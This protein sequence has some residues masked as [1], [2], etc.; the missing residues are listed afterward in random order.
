MTH[1]FWKLT[2]E[3]TPFFWAHTEWPLFSMKILHRIPLLLFSSKYMYIIFIFECLPDGRGRANAVHSDGVDPPHPTSSPHQKKKSSTLE[4]SN[5]RISL[6]FLVF[7][8]KFLTPYLETFWIDQSMATQR[9]CYAGSIYGILNLKIA[10]IIT[11]ADAKLVISGP[12]LAI[13]NAHYV[14]NLQ[15]RCKLMMSHWLINC[16]LWTGNCTKK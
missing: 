11:S 14:C 13:S 15:D 10:F 1:I 5:P 12:I 16:F 2:P 3:K 6:F 8:F 7:I 9:A 4:S